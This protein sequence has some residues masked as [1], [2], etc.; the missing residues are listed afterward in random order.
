VAIA[1][2]AGVPERFTAKCRRA[3]P[4]CLLTMDS[5]GYAE[6]LDRELVIEVLRGG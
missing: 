4:A 5:R 3:C 6:S 2:H 1:S